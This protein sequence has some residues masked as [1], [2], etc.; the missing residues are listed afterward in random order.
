MKTKDN[1]TYYTWKEY[2]KDMK[3]IDWIN[4]DHVIGV[5]RGSLGMATLV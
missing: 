4:C 5:Y 2:A 1:K 3:A